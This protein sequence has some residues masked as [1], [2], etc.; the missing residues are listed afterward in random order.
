MKKKDTTVAE[1]QQR[2]KEL[3]N[4]AREI[5]IKLEQI[6]K[7]K[8]TARKY[9]RQLTNILRKEDL[10]MEYKEEPRLCIVIIPK[11]Q[12]VKRIVIPDWLPK[13]ILGLTMTIA[14]FY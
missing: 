13:F 6:D 4:K 9:G 10:I 8:K 5:E 1:L 11:T 14:F 7:L 3:D 12:K 2:N